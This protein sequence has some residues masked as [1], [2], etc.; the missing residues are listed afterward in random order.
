MSK[1]GAEIHAQVDGADVHIVPAEDA[2][3]YEDVSLGQLERDLGRAD[4]ICWGC[5]HFCRP[6]DAKKQ[7]AL[8]EMWQCYEVCKGKTSD[9]ILAGQIATIYA[10]RIYDPKKA[11]GL[12]AQAWPADM[13]Y[14]HL[15]EHMLTPRAIF[16]SLV[17]AQ[18]TN[19]RS[20]EKVCWRKDESGKL[21]P[22]E[23]NMRML[24]TAQKTLTGMLT[25]NPD[26]FFEV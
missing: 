22:V 26:K 1:R 9:M 8:F 24:D 3:T 10:K 7:A 11:A 2:G 5:R 17:R 19:V 12:A 25:M 20:L 13:V 21:E 14:I 16:L 15:K 6:E 4:D 23:K 18:R